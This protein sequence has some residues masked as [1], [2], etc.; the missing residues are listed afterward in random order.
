[1]TTTR[2]TSG[3][4]RRRPGRWKGFQSYLEKY[5]LGVRDHWEYLERVG[6]MKHLT[7]LLADPILGY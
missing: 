2:S 1:M 7:S 4:T 3:S 6:G 5:V